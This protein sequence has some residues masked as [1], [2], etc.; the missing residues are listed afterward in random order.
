MP[1]G[2]AP[3]KQRPG[4]N[5]T[6]HGKIFRSP[7]IRHRSLLSFAAVIS[8]HTIKTLRFPILSQLLVYCFDAVFPQRAV[9]VA[10]QPVSHTNLMGAPEHVHPSQVITWGG[11]LQDVQ[12][13]PHQLSCG[14]YLVRIR[15]ICF[16]WATMEAASG[17]HRGI[18]P[19]RRYYVTG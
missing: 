6:P 9:L 12:I 18:S 8:A 7:N 15:W 17:Q 19:L 16:S 3:T 5:S 10:H 13:V 11:N 2:W 14:N 1:Y 4:R